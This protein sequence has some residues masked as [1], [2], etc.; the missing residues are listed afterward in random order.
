MI[1]VLFAA[2]FANAQ[3]TLLQS[4]VN[5]VVGSNVELIAPPFI[6]DGHLNDNNIVIGY[7]VL[8]DQTSDSLQQTLYFYDEDLNLVKSFTLAQLG[9]SN[10]ANVS[11]ISR[12]IFTNDGKWAWIRAKESK[13]IEIVTENGQILATMQGYIGALLK[14]RD[15][16]IL[17]VETA[18]NKYNIYSLP[19]NGEATDVSEVSAPQ[20]NARKYLHNDQVLIESNEKTYTIQGQEV[21]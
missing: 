14:I 1:A 18:W 2:T 19:G 6:T 8:D 3:I 10:I 20:K 4:D 5:L 7:Y 11:F 13:Q 17:G 9:V 16:Y 15:K 21:K 12:N